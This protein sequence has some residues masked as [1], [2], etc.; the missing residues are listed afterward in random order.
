MIKLESNKIIKTLLKKKLDSKLNKVQERFLVDNNLT[1][2]DDI[3]LSKQN[4]RT[5]VG[6]RTLVISKDRGNTS[7]LFSPYAY[8]QNLKD[9]KID[10]LGFINK[11]TNDKTNN[12][13]VV[14]KYKHN[15][16]KILNENERILELDK[17]ILIKKQEIETLKK[18]NEER[19]KY[20]TSLLND[21]KELRRK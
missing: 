17:K 2:S 3:S 9:D 13:S 11:S 12:N 6:K 18:Q 19:R 4:Y 7:N 21:N 5:L 1:L 10:L 16:D 20:I 8:L 15:R 14:K